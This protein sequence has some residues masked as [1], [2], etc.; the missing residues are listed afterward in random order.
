MLKAIIG[1]KVR[2]TQAFGQNGHVVALTAIQAGPCPIVQIK[3]PDRDGYCAIQVGYEPD[4][5]TRGPRQPIAGHFQKAKVKPHR[6]LKEFRLDSPDEYQ[7]GQDVTVAGFEPG[8]RADYALYPDEIT[9]IDAS[10][11]H[12][13]CGWSP[14]EGLD[15]VFPEEV[16]V[17]GTRAYVHGDLRET[18][19]AWYPGQGYLPLQNK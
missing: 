2:M 16:V 10:H 6:I 11:L 17:R 3:T 13:K 5:R 9:R 14:F 7:V 12:A 4:K 18:C 19:A 15:A 1:K 8:D